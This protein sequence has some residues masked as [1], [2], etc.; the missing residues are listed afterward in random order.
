M[1]KLD[2]L[3]KVE[4]AGDLWAMRYSEIR[5]AQPKSGAA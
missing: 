1:E 2:D 5:L 3:G 4:I